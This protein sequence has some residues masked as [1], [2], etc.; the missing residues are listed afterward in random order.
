MMNTGH[1]FHFRQQ[2]R[3][4]GLLREVYYH[5][6][7]IGTESYNKSFSSV[8]KEKKCFQHL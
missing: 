1:Q 5:I 2:A 6:L 7:S 3:P 8:S 4:V